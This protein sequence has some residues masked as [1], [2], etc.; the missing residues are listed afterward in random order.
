MIATPAWALVI[1]GLLIPLPAAPPPHG[2]KRLKKPLLVGTVALTVNPKSQ[3]RFEGRGL[4][5][6]R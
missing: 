4:F 3:D 6:S 5:L 2:K 1:T